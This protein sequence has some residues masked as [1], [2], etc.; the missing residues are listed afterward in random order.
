MKAINRAIDRFCL[1]HRRFGIPNLMKYIVFISAGAF[2]VDMLPTP[3]SLFD[4]IAFNPALIM[5]GEV[6]RI[7]TWAFIPL[8]DN[9]LFMALMLYFYY[10]IGVSLER[11]WGTAKFSVFYFSGVLL[12]IIYGFVL[13]LVL[14]NSP[15]ASFISG[16][17][18]SSAIALTPT[19]INL[20]MYFA[21]AT[22]FPNFYIRLFFIIPVK[23]KWVA[24]VNA[25]FFAFSIV[26]GIMLGNFL[27]FL[28]VIALLNYLAICGHELFSAIFRPLKA[29]TSPQTINFKRAAR[30]AKQE[31]EGKD[32]RH[33]CAVCGRTDKDHPDLEFRYCSHCAGYHCF[34]G[35]HINNHV[36]FHQ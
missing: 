30:Q 9:L 17:T 19:Y 3:G 34:C 23:I 25:C 24:I 12:N 32:Y 31:Y 27:A 2:V 10:F 18:W 28:P 14:R 33:K 13:W 8:N 15:V 20:S 29:K 36:H 26:S 11:E 7:V 35:E 16:A 6:W 4:L 22:L 1:K 5:R 21:F